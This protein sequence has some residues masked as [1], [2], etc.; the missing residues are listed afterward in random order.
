MIIIKYH[1]KYDYIFLSAEFLLSLL[2]VRESL[3]DCAWNDYGE[4]TS[5]SKSCGGGQQSRTRTIKIEANNGG[6]ECIGS[7]T[8]VKECN[9]Q[10]C[11]GNVLCY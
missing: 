9:N 11:I 2:N 1:G 4:W 8:D 5:C 3:V 6:K 10:D 7:A